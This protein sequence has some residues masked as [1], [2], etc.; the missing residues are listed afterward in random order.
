[1]C[2]QL[3]TQ[4]SKIESSVSRI[5]ILPSYLI[6][7]FWLLTL[8]WFLRDKI[9]IE[10]QHHKKQWGRQRAGKRKKIVFLCVY[11]GCVLRHFDWR[12]IHIILGRNIVCFEVS[13]HLLSGVSFL[14]RVSWVSI[15]TKRFVILMRDLFV[16][17]ITVGERQWGG[18]WGQWAL[19]CLCTPSCHI[20]FTELHTKY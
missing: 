12:L 1:M 11:H 18:T 8:K 10:H 17:D 3:A 9:N 20:S 13:S 14:I 4:M 15:R 19:F 16:L 2:F 5:Y 7:K 6:F